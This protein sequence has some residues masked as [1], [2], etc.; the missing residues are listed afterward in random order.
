MAYPGGQDD[1]VH[2]LGST[3]RPSFIAQGLKFGT[4]DLGN[5]SPHRDCHASLAMT[6]CGG[7]LNKSQYLSSKF[8]T[9][10]GIGILVIMILFSIS[11]LEFRFSAVAIKL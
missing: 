10:L 3:W 2:L 6:P 8:K 4:A 11:D 7:I 1:N 9:L 5:P